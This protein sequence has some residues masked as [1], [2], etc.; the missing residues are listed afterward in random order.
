ML[1]TDT[2]RRRLQ[3]EIDHQVESISQGRP[4]NYE[5]YRESVGALKGLRFALEAFEK[6]ISGDE[7]DDK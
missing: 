7:E 1:T 3:E 5:S 2:Y 4:Q 6:F